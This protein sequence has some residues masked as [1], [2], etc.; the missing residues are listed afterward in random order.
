MHDLQT[1]IEMNKE[2]EGQPMDKLQALTEY[3]QEGDI[4]ESSYDDSMFETQDGSEYMVL[5]E[6]EADERW[7]DSLDSYL[8][9][10]VYP[11]LAGNLAQYFDD[12]K[13][14][15]DARYDGRG[16]SLSHYDGN[17]DEYGGYL[18]YRMN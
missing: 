18:I 3:L 1:I 13:W 9:D 15:R 11:E 17:E 8:E 6:N 5:T 7:E 14:K 16:R 2:P 12:E 10:Y 4:M